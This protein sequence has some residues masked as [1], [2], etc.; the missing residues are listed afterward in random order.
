MEELLREYGVTIDMVYWMVGAVCGIILILMLCT[1][2]RADHAGVTFTETPLP[3]PGRKVLTQEDEDVIHKALQERDKK[4]TERWTKALTEQYKLIPKDQ[5][6]SMNS[7]AFCDKSGGMIGC[8][9]I[10]WDNNEVDVHVAHDGGIN[11]PLRL[12]AEER[13]EEL[14]VEPRTVG[15]DHGDGGAGLRGVAHRQE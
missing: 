7:V 6:A 4:V 5:G 15:L 3:A 12:D 13:P 2:G 1:G 9:S 14:P 8:V 10:D 11:E